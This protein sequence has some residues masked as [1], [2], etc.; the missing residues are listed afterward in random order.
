MVHQYQSTM[1]LCHPVSIGWL[2]GADMSELVPMDHICSV[3]PLVV[4]T[5]WEVFNGRVFAYLFLKKAYPAMGGW[6]ILGVA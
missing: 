5:Y 4:H 6:G 3:G 1:I 2:S